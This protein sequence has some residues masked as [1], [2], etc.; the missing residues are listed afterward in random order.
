METYIEYLNTSTNNSTESEFGNFLKGGNL[1][2][3]GGFPPVYEC[4]RSCYVCLGW[5]LG[6]LGVGSPISPLVVG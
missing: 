3:D 1:S 4:L 6:F 2:L 5:L